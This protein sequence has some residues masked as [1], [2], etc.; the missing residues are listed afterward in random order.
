MYFDPLMLVLLF[1]L[2]CIM[3]VM[4][5]SSGRKYGIMQGV[6]GTLEFLENNDV[7]KYHRDGTLKV[8]LKFHEK[9][10]VQS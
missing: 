6:D 8:P 4:S 3:V 10:R 2:Y 9:K 1:M 5:F 7:I